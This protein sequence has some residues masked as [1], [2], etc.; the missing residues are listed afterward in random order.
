MVIL[1]NA[2]VK[3][4]TE[5]KGY[6][7]KYCSFLVNPTR[8]EQLFHTLLV[9][10][11]PYLSHANCGFSCVEKG[12][13]I[14]CFAHFNLKLVNPQPSDLGQVIKQLHLSAIFV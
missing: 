1:T 11:Q 6:S 3:T 4:T 7:S 10:G 12:A 5:I 2:F 9:I 8:S 14:F 13:L